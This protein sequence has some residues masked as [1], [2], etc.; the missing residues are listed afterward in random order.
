MNKNIF[1]LSYK[2]SNDCFLLIK[3]ELTIKKYKNYNGWSENSILEFLKNDNSIS[4]GYNH[5]GNFGGFILS[6]YTNIK[7]FSEIEI[8]L[9]LIRKEYRRLGIGSFLIH[10]LIF[11]MNLK[12]LNNI[13]L[14]FSYNNKIAKLFYKNIGFKNLYSRKGYYQLNCNKKEDAQVVNYKLNC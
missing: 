2:D 3:K 11:N 9:I 6:K 12:N 8:S 1:K 13:F 4:L 7:N 14:E 10:H 5:K